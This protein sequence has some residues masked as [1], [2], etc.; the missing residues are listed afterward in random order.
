[1][2]PGI[3]FLR[4]RIAGLVMALL[5]AG[6]PAFATPRAMASADEQA[7]WTAVG[8][9]NITGQ[10][11]CT[12]TL[13]APDLVLT[14]AHCLMDRRTGRTVSADKVHFLPGFRIGTYAAHGR[15]ARL[16][17]MPGYVP[18]RKLVA[19]DVGLVQLSRPM[20]SEIAPIPLVRGG[21]DPA[22][23][24]SL[25]SYGLDRAQILSAQHGC[26][27]DKRQGSVVLTTCEGIPGVSGAPLLQ[28]IGGQWVAVAVASSIVAERRVPLP[29]GAVLAVEAP[30][31]EIGRLAR[32]MGGEALPVEAALPVMAIGGRPAA[33]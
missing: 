17:V 26:R 25:L 1:M 33:P 16:V 3:A 23:H 8:R 24:F 30:V 15:G 20:P 11:F 27:L 32:S 7:E 21:I 12:G 29:V 22:A 2:R 9:L 10:G 28:R 14:A 31:H 19:R 13:V 6:L 4:A 18:G 5:C